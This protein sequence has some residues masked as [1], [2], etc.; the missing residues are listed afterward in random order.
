MTN[1]CRLDAREIRTYSSIIR[2]L[3]DKY[4]RSIKGMDN[5]LTMRIA[6]TR[7][8]G[9]KGTIQIIYRKILNLRV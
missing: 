6:Q 9:I 1:Q 7:Q 2:I 5:Y 4:G 8:E 3:N